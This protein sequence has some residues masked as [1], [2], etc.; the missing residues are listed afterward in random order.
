VTDDSNEKLDLLQRLARI[1]ALICPYRKY[2][3]EV[4]RCPC[5]R[6]GHDVNREQ[7]PQTGCK[8]IQDAIN[9]IERT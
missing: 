1:R 8:D 2:Q 5:V 9:R 4:E 7:G 6:G 3:N